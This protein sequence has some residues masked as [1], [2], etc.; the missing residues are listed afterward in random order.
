MAREPRH[1]MSMEPASNIVK[2]LGG[3]AT[4]TRKLSVHRSRVHAWM[5]AKEAGGTGGTIP[6]RHHLAILRLAKEAG[7]KIRADDLLP[8]AEQ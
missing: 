3:V 2:R 1:T 5:R 8:R 4:L 7:V 6:Q